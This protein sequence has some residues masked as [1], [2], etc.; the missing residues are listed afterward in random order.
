MDKKIGE[1]EGINDDGVDD[2][3]QEEPHSRP[4][5]LIIYDE[6]SDLSLIISLWIEET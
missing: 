4:L 2:M 1:Q 5:D 3:L 6:A